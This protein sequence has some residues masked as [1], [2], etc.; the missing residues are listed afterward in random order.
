[1]F[2]DTSE[3]DLRTFET[4]ALV[5]EPVDGGAIWFESF[6]QPG[7]KTAFG[8]SRWRGGRFA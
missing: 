1:M 5:G 7:M 6:R 2:A 3:E 8:P 4:L